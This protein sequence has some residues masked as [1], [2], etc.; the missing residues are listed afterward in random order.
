MNCRKVIAVVVFGMLNAGVL[1][2]Q[3]RFYTVGD[4]LPAD[5]DL[6][7][8]INAPAKHYKLSDFKGKLLILDFWATWCSTCID[9]M[10]KMYAL[11]KEYG[12]KIIVLPVTSEDAELAGSFWRKNQTLKELHLPS[13]VN[14]RTV[15]SNFP[16]RGLPTEVWIKDGK[17][18]G[19]T[20]A[21]HVN[22]KEIADVLAGKQKSWPLFYQADYDL[23]SSIIEQ[24]SELKWETKKYYYTAFMPKLYMSLPT[25][26]K[27]KADTSNN[28]YKVSAI[29]N[30]IQQYYLQLLKLKNELPLN[31]IVLDGV[32]SVL[33]DSRK[34]TG[35]LSDWE[36]Q[37]LICCEAQLPLYLTKKQVANKIIDELNMYLGL[38]AKVEERE[39][40][41]LV[42]C[43]SKKS[44]KYIKPTS[45]QLRNSHKGID[46]LRQWI[47]RSNAANI[48][49]FE[50]KNKTLFNKP[51][52]ITSFEDIE[53]FRKELAGY[54]LDLLPT[55]RNV[56]IFVL[57]KNPAAQL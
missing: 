32:D 51:M 57:S 31:R 50:V 36:Q 9:E 48:I 38:Q 19:I 46:E 8:V 45:L 18:I 52:Y 15:K 44:V 14:G 5:M 25:S 21:E 24:R 17:V 42:V 4:T 26:F 39:M 34:R 40:D 3:E 7:E 29:N 2:G 37:Y 55:K 43:E 13:I 27:V 33:F 11:Q 47:D 53:E 22:S 6:G 10:P 56:M 41:C 16:M 35:Y 28:C 23:K 1:L 12:D 54:G 20:D 49:L 30:S